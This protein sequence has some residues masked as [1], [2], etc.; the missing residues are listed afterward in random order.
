[1]IIRELKWFNMASKVAGVA[2]TAAYL[3]FP[4]VRRQPIHLRIP[5]ALAP[6]AFVFYTT[7]AM[8]DE[9]YW[10]KGWLRSL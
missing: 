9:F 10:N 1:M 7:K 3:F 8:G 2:V 4:V 6:G 5:I